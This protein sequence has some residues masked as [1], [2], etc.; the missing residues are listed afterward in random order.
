MNNTDAAVD[1]QRPALFKTG[2]SGNPNGR[3][4]GSRNKLGEQVV[5]DLADCWQKHGVAALE[6]CAITE[7]SVFVRVIASLLPRHIDLNL[8]VD[9]AEFAQKFESACT[10]LGNPEPLRLRSPMRTVAGRVINH[11]R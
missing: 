6:A 2:Q 9:A 4:K 10:L 5:S 7:P 3:P 1:Q 8:N 11:G